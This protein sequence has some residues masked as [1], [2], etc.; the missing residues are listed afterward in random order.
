MAA[1][2]SRLSRLW[3]WLTDPEPRGDGDLAR[4]V[5]AAAGRLEVGAKELKKAAK[6]QANL[7]STSSRALRGVSEPKPRIKKKG[8]TGKC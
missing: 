4:H 8:K 2:P 7:F 6:K 5:E 3:A 1:E